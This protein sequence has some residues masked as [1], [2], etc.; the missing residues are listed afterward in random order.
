MCSGVLRQFFPNIRA[1]KWLYFA[2]PTLS[3]SFRSSFLLPARRDSPR[4]PFSS[5]RNRRG[6]P[7]LFW[8]RI[9]RYRPF[10]SD[11]RF[12]ERRTCPLQDSSE[13]TSAGRQILSGGQVPGAVRIRRCSPSACHRQGRSPPFSLLPTI[14]WGS[15]T[16]WAIRRLKSNIAPVTLKRTGAGYHEQDLC[17]DSAPSATAIRSFLKQHSAFGQL[18]DKIPKEALEILSSMVRANAFV[19]EADLD[20]LL[21]YVLALLLGHLRGIP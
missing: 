8:K 1:Q 4:E 3:L 6:H 19:E 9:R 11:G 2:A 15:N 20:L 14:F 13:K 5:G 12:T 18:S 16:A 7:P 10:S 21:H 17:G